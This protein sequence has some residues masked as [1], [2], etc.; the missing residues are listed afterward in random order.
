MIYSQVIP[1][2]RLVRKFRIPHGAGFTNEFG[3]TTSITPR[4]LGKVGEQVLQALS[5]RFETTFTSVVIRD[6]LR[7]G[8]RLSS[9]SRKDQLFRRIAEEVRGVSVDSQV[10]ELAVRVLH[11]RGGVSFPLGPCIAAQCSIPWV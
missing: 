10:D 11:V 9:S 6:C 4:V 7:F 5:N 1:E 3:S 2:L 8:N